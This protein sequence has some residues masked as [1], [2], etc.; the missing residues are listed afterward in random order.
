MCYWWDMNDKYF[1][2][3]SHVFA[4]LRIRPIHSQKSVFS[5]WPI[6]M[7]RDQQHSEADNGSG[8]TG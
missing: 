5:P 3:Q 1:K 2:E 6:A 8:D 4:K 7:M